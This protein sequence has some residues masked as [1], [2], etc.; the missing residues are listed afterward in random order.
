MRAWPER[1]EALA[2]D[3]LNGQRE[4]GGGPEVTAA[5]KARGAGLS[6]VAMAALALDPRDA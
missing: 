1:A 6:E 5:L 3:A 2:R 4:G